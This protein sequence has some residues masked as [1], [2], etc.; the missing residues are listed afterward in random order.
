MNESSRPCHAGSSLL[1]HAKHNMRVAS[2]G[3]VAANTHEA[4][5]YCAISCAARRARTCGGCTPFA[6]HHPSDAYSLCPVLCGCNTFGYSIPDLVVQ[7]LRFVMHGF[8][9]VFLRT[10]FLR[11]FTI[12][13]VASITIKATVR[14][15]A[16]VHLDVRVVMHLFALQVFLFDVEQRVVRY[17]MQQGTELARGPARSGCSSSGATCARPLAAPLWSRMPRRI[18]VVRGRW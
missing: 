13:D 16:V 12:V 14:H 9:C 1:Q 2:R 8:L 3:E 18:S 11:V 4:S 6:A 17:V 10:S 15:R 7:D 5:P